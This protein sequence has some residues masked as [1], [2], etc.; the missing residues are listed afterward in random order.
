MNCAHAAAVL[1]L[2][3]SAGA[4]ADSG[5]CLQAVKELGPD[6]PLFGV[7]MG[8]Q[9]IGEAFGGEGVCFLNCCSVVSCNAPW[10]V[11]RRDRLPQWLF[12]CDVS[13]TGSDASKHTC[14]RCTV[15]RSLPASHPMLLMFPLHPLVATTMSTHC[16]P[17]CVSP[18]CLPC[19]SPCCVSRA[20]LQVMWCVP[21]VV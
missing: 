6:F 10:L 14:L 3:V 8:H 15:F 19:C 7:C 13:A 20:C 12:L 16:S 21:H 4:P 2:C 18:E 17:C 5:I 1:C 11:W 9:C